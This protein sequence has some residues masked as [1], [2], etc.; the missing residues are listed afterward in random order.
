MRSYARF[1]LSFHRQ[2]PAFRHRNFGG[3]AQYLPKASAI[4]LR[5]SDLIDLGGESL[6]NYF[7]GI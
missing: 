7:S 6:G 5:S 4:G 2:N 1:P 3:Q